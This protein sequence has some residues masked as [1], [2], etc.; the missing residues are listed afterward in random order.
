[1]KKSAICLFIILSVQILPAFAI[2]VMSIYQTDVPVISQSTEAR[3]EAAK[4]GLIEVLIKLTGDSNIANRSDISQYIQRADY[5]VQEYGYSN[6]SSSQ[7]EYLI[8]FRFEEDDVNRMLKRL[9]IP[10]WNDNRPLMIV[11]L[12]ASDLKH[13][14]EIIGNESQGYILKKMKE[15]GN[16]YGLPFIF[17]MMDMQDLENISI[18]DINSMS[19]SNIQNASKR[20]SPEA[21]LIGNIQQNM[22]GFQSQ[23]QLNLRGKH[24]NW[25]IADVSLDKILANLVNEIKMTISDREVEVKDNDNN[26]I[27]IKLEVSNIRHKYDLMQLINYLKQLTIV[28]EID[29]SGFSEDGVKIAVLVNGSLGSFIQNAA[30]GQRMILRGEFDEANTLVY[31]WIN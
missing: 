15:E 14:I 1:M 10:Y 27:W 16:K 2:K 7:S 29:T 30:V 18:D 17:P 6:P 22:A 9:D 5:F 25:S 12:T 31:E 13:P 26:T 20:Y 24:W 19:M 23:W 21:Y 8:H 3:S 4:Q 28:K 11:W